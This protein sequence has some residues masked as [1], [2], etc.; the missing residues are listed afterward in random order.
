MRAL[1]TGAT[2]FIGAAITR[3]LAD[4]GTETAILCRPNTNTRRLA[5]VLPKL[6]RLEADLDHPQSVIAALQSFRPDTVFHLAWH[7][8]ASRHRND[9]DQI[10]RNLD[11]SLHLVEAAANLGCSR[12]IGA[13]SQA[14]YGPHEGALNESAPT[15]PT[16][17]YGASKLSAFHLGCRL[18]NLRNLP[19][20]WIRVFSTYGPD[21]NPDWMIP[22]LIRSLLARQRP[23]LTPGEQRWDYLFVE[24]AADAFIAVADTPGATGVFNLG[25]GQAHSLRD[26]VSLVR[27]EIDPSL[28]LGFGEVPY[29]PDQ[30][31]WLQ[32]DIQ[33]L[34]QTTGWQPRVNLHQGI[35]QTIAW[36]RQ[37]NP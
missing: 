17:L 10:H 29:R 7:G 25:S 5:P 28:P 4:R 33:R 11:A 16:T 2:G 20:A 13:G 14:E 27:D 37:N 34:N 22:S 1:V 3:R 24:D 26:V 15:N 8:V 36:H 18:A 32:A 12:W 23:A 9:L 21:D 19:F 6:L 30:V 31:M 35:R